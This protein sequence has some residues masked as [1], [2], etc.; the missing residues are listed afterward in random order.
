MA[1]LEKEDGLE[2]PRRLDVVKIG[3]SVFRLVNM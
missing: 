1:M 3:L 2:L